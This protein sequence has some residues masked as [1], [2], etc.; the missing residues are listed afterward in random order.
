AATCDMVGSREGWSW[1]SGPPHDR[2][3][4]MELSA[5]NQIAG[6]VTAVK[7]G[8]VMAEVTVQIAGGQELV[9]VITRASAEHL[10]LQAGDQVTVIIKSTEVLLGK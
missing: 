3:R 8:G 5:R 7:L 2:R 9:S 4:S 6:T 1:T 10:Q